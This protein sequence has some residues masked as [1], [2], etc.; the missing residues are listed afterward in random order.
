L[1]DDTTQCWAAL[2]AASLQ[3]EAAFAAMRSRA[4]Q[5]ETAAALTTARNVLADAWQRLQ[6]DG[7]DLAGA[8]LPETVARQ[9]QD[10]DTE[11]QKV[12]DRFN[13][14]VAG[15]NAAVTQF[16]ALLLA[17]LFGFRRAA[18]V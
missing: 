9:W 13:E 4:L 16:P 5:P 7:Y 14:A 15:Y 2:Q 1:L 3:V 6:R 8:A 12:Q 18:P 11:A 10:M 17:W